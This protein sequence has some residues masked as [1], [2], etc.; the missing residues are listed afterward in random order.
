[1]H[2]F[3]SDRKK[4]FFDVYLLSSFYI[5][6]GAL[7]KASAYSFPLFLFFKDFHTFVGNYSPVWGGPE[8]NNIKSLKIMAKKNQNLPAIIVM[9]AL[10][11]MIAFVT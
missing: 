8:R 7:G 3:A 1:M 4:F 5:Q 11:F 2:T 9:F 6:A 10:F